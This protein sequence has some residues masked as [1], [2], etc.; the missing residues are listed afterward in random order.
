MTR[1]LQLLKQI[2][3]EQALVLLSRI[4]PIPR[5]SRYTKSGADDNVLQFLRLIAEAI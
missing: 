5:S 3:E 4:S 2:D 1:A